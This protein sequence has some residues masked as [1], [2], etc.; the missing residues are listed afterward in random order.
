M[1]PLAEDVHNSK[2]ILD[3]LSVTTWT[4]IQRVKKFVTNYCEEIIPVGS[5]FLLQTSC[6]IDQPTWEDFLDALGQGT[7]SQPWVLAQGPN[8]YLVTL[9]P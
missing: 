8:L 3:D 2:V 1:F 5:D 6:E 4:A 9:I 7:E